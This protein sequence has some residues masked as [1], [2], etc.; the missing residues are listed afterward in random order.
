MNLRWPSHWTVDMAHYH[1]TCCEKSITFTRRLPHIHIQ[2]ITWNDGL[3]TISRYRRHAGT[4]NYIPQY[5]WDIVTCPCP[6]YLLLAHKSTHMQTV[7]CVYVTHDDVIK[8]KHFSRYW[9]F[10][11]G[12]PPVSCGLPKV[13]QWRGCFL[14][15]AWTSGWANDRN[16]GDWGAIMLSI[17]FWWNH[18]IHVLPILFK[19]ASSS[20]RWPWDSLYCMVHG[21]SYRRKLWLK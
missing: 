17:N 1:I 10:V 3:C 16:T 9:H 8:W 20:L 21:Q 18:M 2:I 19:V 12:K 5:L 6:P 14:W 11:R 15:C 4:S 13:P 7:C